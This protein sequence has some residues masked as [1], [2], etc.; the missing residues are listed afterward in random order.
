MSDPF[1]IL[2]VELELEACG[3]N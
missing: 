3:F 1:A 2:E